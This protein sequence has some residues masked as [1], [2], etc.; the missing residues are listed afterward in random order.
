MEKQIL[1]VDLFDEGVAINQED[2]IGSA[3]FPLAELLKTKLVQSTCPVNDQHGFKNG[4][5]SV[6]L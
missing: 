1:I 5:L 2:Y 4:E 3:R 6:V